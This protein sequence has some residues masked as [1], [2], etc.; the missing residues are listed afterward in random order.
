MV[1]GRPLQL[2]IPP[3]GQFSLGLRWSP[4]RRTRLALSYT[5]V[6]DQ[7]ARSGYYS[8]AYPLLGYQYA[9]LTASRDLGAG[10]KL[11]AALLNMF[12][13]SYETQPGFPRPGRNWTLGL[14]R[15][16]SMK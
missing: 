10:W 5:N 3:K 6:G 8:M 13:E 1:E 4:D 11:N 15:T 16:A 12:N 2:A 7:I 9:N 14:S